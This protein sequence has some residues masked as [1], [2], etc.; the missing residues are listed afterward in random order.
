MKDEIADMK[1]VN[2]KIQQQFEKLGQTYTDEHVDKREALKKQYEEK[3]GK[4]KNIIVGLQ[5]KLDDQNTKYWLKKYMQ[6]YRD[7]ELM[8]NEVQRLDSINQTL[9]DE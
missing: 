2:N 1:Q 4:Q 6:G 8:H 9:S 5:Q 7:L 3:L